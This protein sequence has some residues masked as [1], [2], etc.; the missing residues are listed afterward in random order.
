MLMRCVPDRQAERSWWSLFFCGGD[1]NVH[2]LFLYSIF[3]FRNF[4]QSIQ[5]N[6]LFA[7]IPHNIVFS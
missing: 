4:L 5:Q 7:I 6:G 3:I 1:V 2:F